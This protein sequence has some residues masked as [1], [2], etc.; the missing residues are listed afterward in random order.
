MIDQKVKRL[1]EIKGWLVDL[2]GTLYVSDS[3][4]PGATDFIKW[5]RAG[6]RHYRFV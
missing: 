2:D 6:Q 4:V 3:A 5:L 1:D